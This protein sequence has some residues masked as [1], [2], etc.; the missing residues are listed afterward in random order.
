MKAVMLEPPRLSGVDENSQSGTSF[1]ES[2]TSLEDL[3]KHRGSWVLAALMRNH[4]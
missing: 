4:L 2:G 1:P 3:I